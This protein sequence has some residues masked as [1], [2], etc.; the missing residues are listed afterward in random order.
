MIGQTVSHYKIMAKIGAG[1]MGEVYKAEDT[2][3]GRIVALKFLPRERFQ[4]PQV[5]ARFLQEA[6]AASSLD[7]G[8]ICTIHE[9]DETEDGRLFIA[10][11]FY[12]GETLKARI[13]K[14]PLSVA[15]A[16]DIAL[17]VTAGLKKAHEK[18]IV[19]RDI[20]PAN[21]FLTQEE[22]VKILDFGLAKLSGDITLTKTGITM[23]TVAYMSPE[24]ARGEP[25]DQ[26]TD[27]WSLGVML[28][29]MLSGELPFK[30]IHEQAVINAILNQEPKPLPLSKEKLPWPW[31]AL[32]TRA[33]KKDR[34]DRYPSISAVQSDLEKIE[35]MMSKQSS[36]KIGHTE[37]QR[38]SLAVIP[39][40]NMSADSEN[41]Y[42]SDGLT[43]ELIN[44]LTGLK[45]FRV[46]A[47]TSAF[48]FKGKQTD[49]RDIGNQLGVQYVLEGS[50]RKSG[51]RVRITAQLITVEDGCHLW[52]EKYDR[53]LENVFAIQ[54]EIS[55]EIAHKLQSEFIRTVPK[56]SKK[57]RP[58]LGAYELYLKGRYYFNKF[59]PEWMLKA[60]ET[61]REAI[62]RDPA[63]APTHTGL[64]DTYIILTNPIGVLD[65]REA[66]PK[67]RDAAEQA[68]RLDPHLSEAYA[69]LGSVATF[70]DWDSQ[71]ARTYFDKAVELNPDDVNT[72][73]WYELALSL[74]DQDYDAALNHMN[75]ALEIDP[76][77]LIIL[78]RT[79]YLYVYKYDYETAIEYF[80]KI[81]SIEP[82][83]VSGHHGLVDVYGL[84]GKY[85]L[86]FAEGE[87]VRKLGNEGPAFLAVLALYYG[88]SGNHKEAEAIHSILLKR[89]ETEPISPFWIGVIFMGLD[90][91]DRM[92]EWFD[93]ALE[94]R[95]SN[96]LYT[97]APPFDSIREDSRFKTLRKKMGLKL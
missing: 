97:F 72:R 74:L 57:M 32:L 62:V 28:Y 27:I 23:G 13:G 31:E 61:F 2:R 59:S 53:D 36:N 42:F 56:M 81:I 85:E 79:G 94:K 66:L 63:F 90:Q 16:L 18:G 40:V 20:K 33:L 92:Y 75:E 24:Q 44:A 50:V 84:Q 86:V 6:R 73:L 35:K 55:A 76:L 38:P 22:Q 47:R 89:Y 46:V 15:K 7:H 10:M 41:E 78:L 17:Q 19:H 48:A 71:K 51:N 43:E 77:N 67:A 95:D 34:D 58:D 60:Q 49:I 37:E 68:L 93:R 26:R 45:D 3:L 30:G 83:I 1:G 65:G 4:D 25:V 91:L 87:K 29:E 11:A 21:I 9:C 96:L 64:A 39:F 70:L 52:S 8:N 69:A 54:D 12:E 80:K 14:S 88:R 5:K 82:E